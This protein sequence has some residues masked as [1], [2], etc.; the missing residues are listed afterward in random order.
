MTQTTIRSRF[1]KVVALSSQL[2]SRGVM[3]ERGVQAD[4][5]FWRGFRNLYL[6][7]ANIKLT[8]I[9]G[10][11]IDYI[12]RRPANRFIAYSGMNVNNEHRSSSVECMNE[13]LK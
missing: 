11:K 10:G 12:N 9:R 3:Y 6:L 1:F 13:M 8:F 2:L 5:S 4:F 7:S